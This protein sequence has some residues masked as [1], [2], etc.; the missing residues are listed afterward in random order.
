[1]TEEMEMEKYSKLQNK[2]GILGVGEKRES[3]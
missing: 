3:N 2:M 1:M